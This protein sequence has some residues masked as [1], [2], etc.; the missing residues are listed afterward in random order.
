VLGKILCITPLPSNY[1]INPICIEN[2]IAPKIELDIVFCILNMG[3]IKD[4]CPTE[5]VGLDEFW[6]NIVPFQHKPQTL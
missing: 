3:E 1:C 5:Q 6:N 4:L 2:F